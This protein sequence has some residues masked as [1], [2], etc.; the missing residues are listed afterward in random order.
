M[1][2]QRIN[3]T[4][5]EKVF[6]VVF[7]SYSTASFTN[8]QVACWDWTT[9][10]DGVSVSI[11]TATL[12]TPAGSDVAG[13]AAETI[14]FG[15][16][17]LVQV[18]GYH[19]AA[20]VRTMTATGHAYHESLFAVAKGVRLAGGLTTAFCLE[21]VTAAETAFVIEG[22]GFAFAAQAQVTTAAIAIFIKA[23]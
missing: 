17:G 21:G 12:N 6:I 16:Y 7:N 23:L 13:I 10:G 18:Y 14:A 2:F 5:P 9:D 8:G 22:C 4:D 11:P 3:R 15:S 19:S 20:R 1:L